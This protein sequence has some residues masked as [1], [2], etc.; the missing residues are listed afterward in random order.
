[1]EC[2]AIDVVYGVDETHAPEGRLKIA[3]RFIAGEMGEVGDVSSPGGTIELVAQGQISIV[4]PG[5]DNLFPS[6]VPS[7]KSLGYFRPTLRVEILA[8]SSQ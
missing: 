1:M 7:D 4:P 6:L 3:Q 8:G 2:L 5:R